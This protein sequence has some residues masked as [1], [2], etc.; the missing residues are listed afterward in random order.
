MINKLLFFDHQLIF[1][2]IEK[3]DQAEEDRLVRFK[4]E[5]EMREADELRKMRG[6]LRV[7]MR[8]KR[9]R[10]FHFLLFLFFYFRSFQI[11]LIFI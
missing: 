4:F 10:F 11:S 3:E 8:E 2:Y 9:L 5:E 1:I 7:E 6:Q